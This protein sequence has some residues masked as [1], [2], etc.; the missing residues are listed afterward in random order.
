MFSLTPLEASDVQSWSSSKYSKWKSCVRALQQ[1]C[2]EPEAFYARLTKH[3]QC[4]L[5]SPLSCISAFVCLAAGAL[6]GSADP[7]V[8]YYNVIKVPRRPSSSRRRVQITSKAFILHYEL[9]LT[10]SATGNQT[11]WDVGLC[12]L[13]GRLFSKALPLF[14]WRCLN[15]G[16]RR[17]LSPKRGI[18]RDRRTV[19]HEELRF[20]CFVSWCVSPSHDN[21]FWPRSV[22]PE[23]AKQIHR[24]VAGKIGDIQEANSRL[25]S[26]I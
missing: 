9:P 20:S 6:L 21:G 2:N 13:K 26:L 11:H 12:L 22:S 8:M 15:G 4:F 3:T 24:P 10:A 7:S 5:C 17:L 14:I 16:C 25:T 1:L 23:G 18:K 19:P